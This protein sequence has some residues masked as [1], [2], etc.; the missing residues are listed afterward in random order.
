[1]ATKRQESA[2]VIYEIRVYEPEAG[3]ADAMRD[4]FKQYVVS[5]FAKH[6]IELVGAF[7]PTEDDGRLIYITRFE[8]EEKRGKGWAAFAA[9]AEWL[10]IK[11]RSETDGP[12]LKRQSV[13]VLSPALAGL[14]LK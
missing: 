5:R 14:L 13:S 8:N 6:G 10:E 4:R 9:D 12:L 2:A 3:K 7:E 11:A 1:V